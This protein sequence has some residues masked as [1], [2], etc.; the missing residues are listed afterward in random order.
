MVRT[1]PG[2]VT[3]AH[4]VVATLLPF[5][6]RGGFFAKAQP[7]RSYAMAV[8]LGGGVPEGMYLSARPAGRCGR[9]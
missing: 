8:R 1:D 6:D 2:S 3:A 7:V 4:V 5:V 9:C